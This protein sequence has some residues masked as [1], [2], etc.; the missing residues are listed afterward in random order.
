MGSLPEEMH[1]GA[2]PHFAW[3]KKH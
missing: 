1:P 2:L 3:I